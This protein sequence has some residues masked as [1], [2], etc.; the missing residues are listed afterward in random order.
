MA[1]HFKRLGLLALVVLLIAGA[2]PALA[3]DEE[4]WPT[5]GWRTSTPEEQGMDSDRLADMLALI[6]DESLYI[7]G[8]VVIR[9]GYLVTEAYA[10]PWE[11]DSLH[12]MYSVTKSV[13]ATLVG[14]AV[15]QGYIESVDQPVLDF[16]PDR[17]F[18]NLDEA[19]QV[20]TLADFLTM[21]AG[22]D[23]PDIS[24]GMTFQ[25]VSSSDWVQ[26]VLDR[27]VVQIPGTAFLYNNG[28]P[29][30]LSAVIEAATG[31]TTLDFAAENLFAPLGITS[32]EWET[33]PQGIASGGFGLYLRPRDMAKIGYLYLNEG[34]WDGEQIISAD[35]AA[36]A[37]EPH[38]GVDE[39][40]EQSYGYLWWI[41]PDFYAAQGLQG[42]LIFVV[43]D[44]NLVVA[45]TS[46]LLGSDEIW[47]FRLLQDYILPA[48]QSDEALPAN[49]EAES[50]L[51]DQIEALA[52]D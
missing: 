10:D 28:V 4:Y 31:T 20:A 27:P 42:Q 30:V 41:Y 29:H 46:E 37:T 40:F 18:D 21:T 13:I 44:Q 33:D 16:F 48:I 7:H 23:W 1:A 15:N 51:H 34:Q 35:W 36:A 25:M 6:E 26:F 43:P 49:P 2:L 47:P 19:K 12:I 11:A 50:R 45:I 52:D 39:S 32:Y 9:N 14:I 3:Q 8:V 38:I 24:F 5:N 17:P 22:L